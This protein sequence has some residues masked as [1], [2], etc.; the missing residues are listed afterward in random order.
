MKTKIS[1]RAPQ[2][3]HVR[4]RGIAIALSICPGFVAPVRVTPG[5]KKRERTAEA[6][7]PIAARLTSLRRKLLAWYRKNRRDYP[8]RNTSNWFHLLMAEMMLRRTRADQVVPVYENF[9][10]SYRNPREAIGLRKKELEKMFRPLG[11]RWR[12]GQLH[13]TIHFLHDHYN[14]RK[15]APD[16]DL[17]RIPG[18]GPYTD[19]MLRNRLFGEARAA[20]DSNL[21]RIFLRWQGLPYRPEA[22]RDRGL[23][24]I[25]DRFVGGRHSRELNLALIDF[26][27]LV[28]R[29]RQPLCTECPLRN[30]CETGKKF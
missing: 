29:P 13:E 10:S 2:F 28:C 1:Q 17:Q 16:D 15:P 19:A 20:M 5:E 30:L 26:V 25:G 3:H 14:L 22:R 21:V 24:Q 8:W 27:A 9:V 18:V 12:A 4:Q 6:E 23:H 11:L 7:E